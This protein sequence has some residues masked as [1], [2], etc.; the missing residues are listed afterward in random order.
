MFII[1]NNKDIIKIY[2]ICRIKG[3]SIDI[4]KVNI[5]H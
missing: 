2:F 1:K 3:Y 4:V 5:Q